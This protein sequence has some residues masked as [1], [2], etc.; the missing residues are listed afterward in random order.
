MS[1]FVIEFAVHRSSGFIFCL[2][3]PFNLFTWR[4]SIQDFS[5]WGHQWN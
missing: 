3:T 2:E 5:W 1:A 4:C